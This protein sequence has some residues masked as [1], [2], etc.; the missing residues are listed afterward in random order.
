MSFYCSDCN[1]KL[2]RFGEQKSAA[3]RTHAQN[4]LQKFF[5]ASSPKIGDRQ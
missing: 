2:H 3:A 5:N 4:R 1:L